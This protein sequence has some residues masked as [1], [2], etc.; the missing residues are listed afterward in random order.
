MA[1]PS[2]AERI[3]RVSVIVQCF[4]HERYLLEC[5]ES[6]R[7]QSF[8]DFEWIIIDDCSTDRSPQ[9]IRDWIRD[10]RPQPC[11]FLPLQSNLGVCKALNRALRLATGEFIAHIA[12]DD[13]WRLDF[14]EKL[15]GGLASLPRDYAAVFS[16]ANCIDEQGKELHSSFIGL[17]HQRSGVDVQS[18]CQMLGPEAKN[19]DRGLFQQLC[20]FNFIPASGIIL[21]ASAL[22]LVGDY[23]ETL[24]YED[25]DMWLRLAERFRLEWVQEPL[26]SYRI[27]QNSL[28]RT[29]HDPSAELNPADQLTRCRMAL[30]LLRSRRIEGTIR[31]QWIHTL[32]NSAISLFHLQDQRA[33]FF[34]RRAALISRQPRLVLVALAASAGLS[35]SDLRHF[36]RQRAVHPSA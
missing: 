6:I 36:R 19:T 29:L 8:Q 17:Y 34:L 28:H 25:W 7:C 27:L 33:G 11:C 21:R 35:S 22:A 1:S 3:P 26:L 30:R 13:V 4:N 10:H 23:D 5:L 20:S 16:D 18:T 12:T 9:L 31:R 24:A 14:L 15:V 2:P 32:C